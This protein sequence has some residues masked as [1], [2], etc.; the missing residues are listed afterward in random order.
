LSLPSTI[1]IDG[2]AASGKS[3]VAARLAQSL[4]YLYFDTGVMYRAVTWAVIDRDIDPA[5]EAKTSAVAENIRIEVEADGPDDGRQYTVLVDG[6]DVTWAI[7]QSRVDAKV[8]QVSSYPR[9]R[10][11]LTH[12]QRR[13]AS[14]GSIVM[15]GRDI[16]TVVLPDADLKIFLLASPEERAR[17][18]YEQAIEQK[19]PADYDQILAGII[20]RDRQDETNP[21]SPTKPADDAILVNTD[22]LSIDAVVARLKQLVESY[23]PT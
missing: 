11:A 2:F 5:N 13:I 22:P 15:V 6:Q 16:G 17:R 1:A 21:V 4:G 8:S 3:T 12:Q 18:R 14:A 10:T 7:R 20:A 19:M 23:E 9:V